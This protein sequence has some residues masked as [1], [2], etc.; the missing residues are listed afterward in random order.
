MKS[1][2]EFKESIQEEADKCG[3]A[4]D[5]IR[6]M[7]LFCKYSGGK[8]SKEDGERIANIMS[9]SATELDFNRIREAGINGAKAGEDLRNLFLKL[10]SK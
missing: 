7:Y 2:K 5:S 8:V 4:E 1:Y 3:I 6:A 9:E 10:N